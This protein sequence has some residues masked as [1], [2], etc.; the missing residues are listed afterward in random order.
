MK[1]RKEYLASSSQC[2]F[3]N[4]AA[5]GTASVVFLNEVILRQVFCMKCTKRWQ[6]IYTL[7]GFTSPKLTTEEE[8]DHL[9]EQQVYK[10]LT[11]Y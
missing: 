10:D 9:I 2:P 11:D 5:M 1:T 6:E 4:N 3:C 8:L 7:S